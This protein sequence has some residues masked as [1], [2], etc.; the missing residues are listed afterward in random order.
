MININKEDVKKVFTKV[1]VKKSVGPDGV[2]CKLQKV[3]V[4]QLC[5]VHSTLVTWSLKD[6]IV[7]GVWKTSM[8]CP[9]PKK[10][11]TLRLIRLRTNRNN[12]CCDEM[13]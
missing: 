13:F 12:I 5:Q 11:F 6:G 8:I 1:N 9:I 2:C 7:P 3:C 10:Q 4:P